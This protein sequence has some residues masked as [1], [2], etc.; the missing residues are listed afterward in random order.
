MK[1]SIKL[2]LF[3]A[4]AIAMALGSGVASADTLAVWD[5]NTGGTAEA[6]LAASNAVVDIT[7]SG[8]VFNDLSTDTATAR[9]FFGY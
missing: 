4:I 5:M 8:L 2:N 1:R 3:A 7:V 9:G 6:R